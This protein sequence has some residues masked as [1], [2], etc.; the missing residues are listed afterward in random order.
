MEI[1]KKEELEE[2]NYEKLQEI[3]KKNKINIVKSR[4]E[5]GTFLFGFNKCI[6][7][8]LEVQ[9]ENESYEELKE[10]D[11][12]ELY[13][14]EKSNEKDEN[15]IL[16][17]NL[18][19][20]TELG[21]EIYMVGNIPELGNWDYF[22]AKKLNYVKNDNWNGDLSIKKEENIEF[23][24][25]KKNTSGIIWENGENRKYKFNKKLVETYNTQWK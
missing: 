5:S 7:S 9:K 17:I 6:E 19:V 11:Y 23:K 22:R 16:D 13:S 2:L 4:N 18:I 3:C 10:N 8:I 24:F 25:I 14:E 20:N 21:E 15:F 1:Y 12:K